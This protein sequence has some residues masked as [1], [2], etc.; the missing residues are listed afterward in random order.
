MPLALADGIADVEQTDREEARDHQTA[1]R[2]L[3]ESAASVA[4]R[5]APFA[6]RRSSPARRSRTLAKDELHASEPTLDELPLG[7]EAQATADSGAPTRPLRNGH[8]RLNRSSTKYRRR[9]KRGAPR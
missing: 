9:T 1:T 8:E 4:R 7:D 6:W 3:G 5:A 2:Q